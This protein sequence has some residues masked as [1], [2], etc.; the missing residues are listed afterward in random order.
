MTKSKE[1]ASVAVNE[2]TKTPQ[3]YTFKDKRTREPP[4]LHELE[5][6]LAYVE[7]R[8][9]VL[10]AQLEKVGRMLAHAAEHP[11][12]VVVP[13]VRLDAATYHTALASLN[14]QE[15]A[16]RRRIAAAL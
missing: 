16:L 7:H 3:E 13:R 14:E 2:A 11:D 15:A 1:E 10:R 12:E 5:D 4:T 9:R 6:E 8:E